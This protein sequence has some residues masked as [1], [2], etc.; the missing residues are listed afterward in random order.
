MGTEIIVLVL[1]NVEHSLTLAKYSRKIESSPTK[2]VAQ[3][4]SVK[5][6]FLEILQNSQENNC[7]RVPFKHLIKKRYSDT[8]VS[9]RIL[10]ISKNTFSYRT[11]LVATSSLSLLK[12][13]AAR[14]LCKIDYFQEIYS[15]SKKIL[16]KVKILTF[17]FFDLSK[18]QQIS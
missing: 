7:A 10:R 9:L 13:A 6:L 4:C 3:S 15:S 11:P 14:N 5:K 1:L 2:S 17:K 18:P 16:P 12:D 8:G